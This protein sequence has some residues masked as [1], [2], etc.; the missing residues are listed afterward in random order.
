MSAIE[1]A[2]KTVLVWTGKVML[3]AK[4]AIPDNPAAVA[5]LVSCPTLDRIERDDEILAMLRNERVATLYAPLLT[6]EEKAS[7]EATHRYRSDAEFLSQR[8]IDVRAW[9][10]SNEEVRNLPVAYVGAGS[11]GAAAIC[12]AAARADLVN[13]V[14]SIDGRTDLASDA[15]RSVRT[16]TLLIVDDMPLL[17]MNREALTQL[18]GEKRIEVL[19][20]EDEKTPHTI[21]ERIQL[22]V[23][24]KL[25]PP[26]E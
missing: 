16:P 9:L 11:S 13:T 3:E 5:I 4:L 10:S 2:T 19:H 17:R 6:D 18:R 8:L 26:G 25:L 12:A 22:W 7:D 23:V 20:G 1:E 24:E 15:F 14:I 21:A